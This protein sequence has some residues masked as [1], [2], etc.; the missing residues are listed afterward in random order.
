[1]MQHCQRALNTNLW[2]VVVVLDSLDLPFA[3][4][5]A[6]A[7]CLSVLWLLWDLFLHWDDDDQAE[8]GADSKRRPKHKFRIISCEM[9]NRRKRGRKK[10]SFSPSLVQQ[11]QTNIWI[12]IKRELCW[13]SSRGKKG[14]EN[15]FIFLF[16]LPTTPPSSLTCLMW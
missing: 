11:D 16:G 1:M 10:P 9:V 15:I 12:N 5:R 3:S 4:I 7:A 14:G 13:G 2:L 8:A 6:A